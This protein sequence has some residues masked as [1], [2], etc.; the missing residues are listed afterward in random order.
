MHEQR[1]T[2]NQAVYSAL[3]PLLLICKM[4]KEWFLSYFDFVTLETSTVLMLNIFVGNKWV[5]EKGRHFGHLEGKSI[6][7]WSL[8]LDTVYPEPCWVL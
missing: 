6:H 7:Q 2:P 4:T 3:L 8:L 5:T 1:E